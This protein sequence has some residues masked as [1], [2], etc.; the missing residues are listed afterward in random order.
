MTDSW[1]KG[2]RLRISSHVL[3]DVAHRVL[4]GSSV[5]AVSHVEHVVQISHFLETQIRVSENTLISRMDC[6]VRYRHLVSRANVLFPV[7][8]THPGEFQEAFMVK[9]ILD[10]QLVAVPRRQSGTSM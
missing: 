4:V 5:E 3:D 7:H 9:N 6:C 8:I 1:G 2:R 10:A